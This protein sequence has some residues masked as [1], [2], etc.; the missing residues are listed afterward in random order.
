MATPHIQLRDEPI[1]SIRRDCDVYRYACSSDR[2]K[3]LQVI[4]WI[5]G[6]IAFFVISYGI[7][8][9]VLWGFSG[10]SPSDMDA[11]YFAISLIYGIVATIIV[12]IIFGLCGAWI[13]QCILGCK[14]Y[15][16]RKRGELTKSKSE[17]SP[18]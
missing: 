8:V 5:C 15:Y 17:N 10:T 14:N 2:T 4:G 1:N 3:Y 12:I 13:Y 18:E 16:A 9:L 6:T 11:G 7:G